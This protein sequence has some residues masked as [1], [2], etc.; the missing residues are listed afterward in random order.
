LGDSPRY[1]DWALSAM[2]RLSALA[3]TGQATPGFSSG[4][5]GEW[6]VLLKNLP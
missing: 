2:T 4:G 1:A 3:V 5:F 6:Q